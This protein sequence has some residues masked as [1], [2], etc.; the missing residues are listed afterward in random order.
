[1]YMKKQGTPTDNIVLAIQADSGGSPDGTDIDTASIDGSGLSTSFGDE[2][3]TFSSAVAT[4]A[5][6]TYWMVLRR[7][8]TLDDSNDYVADGSV[9]N[10]YSE[11]FL[12]IPTVRL[13]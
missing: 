7:S 9:G 12:L 11:I 10:A 8:S 13:D 1:M 4:T 2:T 6:T 3:F 5:N